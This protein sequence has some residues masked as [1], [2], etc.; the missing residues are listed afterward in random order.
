MNFQEAQ[1]DDRPASNH[2]LGRRSQAGCLAEVARTE[3]TRSWSRRARARPVAAP[4]GVFTQFLRGILV[5]RL[6]PVGGIFGVEVCGSILV[7]LLDWVESVDQPGYQ[8]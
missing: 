8:A 4:V 1:V 2:M 7:I 3:A 5:L 6:P